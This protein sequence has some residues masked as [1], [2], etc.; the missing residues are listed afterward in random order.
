MV[1]SRYSTLVQPGCKM[2]WPSTTKATTADLQDYYQQ[3]GSHS[4]TPLWTAQEDIL[5]SG[6]KSRAEP[7]VWHWK[8]LRRQAVR[9]AQLIGTQ[10]AERRVLILL[11]PGLEGR[12][13][14]TNS[15]FAGIQIV[16]QGEIARA[17]RHT[18]AA[19]RFIVESEGG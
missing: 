4:I 6:P 18:P 10:Y 8:E 19:L 9:A 2:L 1:C 3:L 16:M 11:N 17:H 7:Y 13:A 14:T 5:V 15:L 12:I